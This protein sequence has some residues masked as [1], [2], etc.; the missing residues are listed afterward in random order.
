MMEFRIRESA[1]ANSD[2]ISSPGEGSVVEVWNG[3]QVVA[4]V[5][6]TEEGVRIVAPRLAAIERNYDGAPAVTVILR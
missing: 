2:D 5:Y 1:A 6:P 3:R 4:T